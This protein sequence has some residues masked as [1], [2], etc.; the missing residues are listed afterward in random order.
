MVVVDDLFGTTVQL[1][2][3]ARPNAGRARLSIRLMTSLLLLK[4]TY[5]ESDE[6]GIE[7]WSQDV[8]FQYFSGLDYFEARKP[9]DPTQLGR[10]RTA[11]GEV[12]LAEILART[13]NTAVMLNAITPRELETVIVD[14]TVQEKAIAHPTDSRLL[15]LARIKLVRCAKHAGMVLKQTFEKEG[16]ACRFRAG[17]YVHAKQF[18][19]L[20]KVV[21]RQRTIVGILIREIQRK[22]TNGLVITH[23]KGLIVGAKTF[24]N[25]PYDGHT[26]AEQIL[27]TNIV[28]MDQEVMVKTVYADLGYRGVDESLDSTTLIHRGRAKS[29]TKQQRRNL[30]R[31]Q[32]IEPIIGHV[33][34]DHGMR[35]CWLKGQIGDALHTISCALG[36]NIRWLMRAIVRLGS[37]PFFALIFLCYYLR[38]WQ[39][40]SDISDY[41]LA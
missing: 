18:K 23:K 10:F 36:F 14:T 24:P 4:H 6:K 26:L 1:A 31:R 41:K 15:E 17:G 28:L 37:K 20:R 9:C 27:Q 30:K 39:K 12:G 34:Q 33:K 16:K 32:A 5:N 8:Y 13:V 11:I 40:N 22:M 2:G 21:K 19:R 25:N 3:G 29:L 35:R 7:R 38:F